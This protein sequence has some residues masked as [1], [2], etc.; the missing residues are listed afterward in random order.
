[1]RSEHD[2]GTGDE[3][4][5]S[6][7]LA[8]L[9]RTGSNVVVVG[10]ENPVAHQAVCQRLLGTDAP[11]TRLVVRTAPGGTC[12]WLPP[13]DEAGETH[14]ITYGDPGEERNATVVDSDLLG[15]L[16]QAVADKIDGVTEAGFEPAEFRVCLDSLGP[17]FSQHDP[18]TV[19]RL[20][21]LVTARV[22]AVNGMGHFHLR[23]APDDDHVKLLEPLFDAVVEVRTKDDGAEH[24]W[25]LLDQNVDSEWIA[26]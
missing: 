4:A 20:V 18:E 19:F 11:R 8:T 16:G 1:M 17:L 12:G 9:K 21:H 25:R 26:L 6:Q 3:S 15:P 13:M 24:R 7:A 2:G 14:L 5:F 23:L 22:R 10:A